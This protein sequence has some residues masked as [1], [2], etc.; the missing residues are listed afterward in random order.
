MRKGLSGIV[1][2]LLLVLVMGTTVYADTFPSPGNTTGLEEVA[3]SWNNKIDE[4]IEA[5]NENN[6]SV[7]ITKKKATTEQVTEA[8]EEVKKIGNSE[9]LGMSDLSVENSSAITSKGLKITLKVPGVKS[10]DKVYV[11]H[12]ISTGWERLKATAGDG[13][14]TCTMY[15]FSPIVV[16]RYNGTG[17]LEVSDPSKGN[18]TENNGGGNTSNDTDNNSHNTTGDSLNN[19]QDNSQANNNNQN[20]SQSNSQPNNNNQSNSQPNNNDQNNSQSNNQSNPQTNNQTQNN[21]VNVTVNYPGQ[22]TVTNSTSGKGSSSNASTAGTGASSSYA[23]TAGAATSP[24]TGSSLPALPILVVFAL[25]SG[26][27]AC[28]KKAKS[29]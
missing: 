21:P 19:S 16:I 12:K 22:N 11:L 3:Q 18:D 5:L 17:E 25:A 2:S 4:N 14:V 20:S 27:V 28:G 7:K 24:K 26:I 8:N 10:T 9:I 23:A 15:S 29:N 6:V 13:T 1:I